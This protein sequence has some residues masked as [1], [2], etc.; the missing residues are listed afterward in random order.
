MLT[1]EGITFCTTGAKVVDPIVLS[2]L[3]VE[4]GAVQ[5][6]SLGAA[7]S[8]SSPNDPVTSQMA[9][10]KS[11][12]RTICQRGRR[13]KRANIVASSGFSKVQSLL[14]RS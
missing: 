3:S 1:T 7:K 5:R 11:M 14:L 2:S 10:G 13:T 12:P 9:I 8:R 4:S 6:V